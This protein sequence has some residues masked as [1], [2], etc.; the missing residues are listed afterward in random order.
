M[1]GSE[2]DHDEDVLVYTPHEMLVEGLQCRNFSLADINQVMEKTNQDRLQT[3][4]GMNSTAL[5]QMWEDLQTTTIPGARLDVKMRDLKMFFCTLH[6]FKRHQVEKERIGD[7]FSERK[8][9]DHGW[10]HAEK[11]GALKGI[12]I[13][14][15][16]DNFGNDIWAVS[17]DG[18]H[19]RTYEKRSATL[20]LDPSSFSYKNK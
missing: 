6:F 2:S 14:W 18:T 5:A 7:L 13:V 3:N 4:Y 12:K 10:Y 16:H 1:S 8:N 15:P 20:N 11:I 9:R 19:F 17:V